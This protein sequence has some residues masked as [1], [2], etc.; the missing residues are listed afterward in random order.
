MRW[1]FVPL[2]AVLAGHPLALAEQSQAP[3][4]AATGAMDVQRLDELINNLDSDAHR[5]GGTNAVAGVQATFDHR[6]HQVESTAG[7]VG[8]VTQSNVGR[9]R[10]EAE[11]AVHAQ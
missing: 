8:L 1:M 10:R 5:E 7:R 3:A 6:A 2:L 4:P 9:T 11:T